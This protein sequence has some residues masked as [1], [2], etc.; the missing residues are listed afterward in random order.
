[1]HSDV[2]STASAAG[3]AGYFDRLYDT[4][5][6]YWWRHG[7]PY[8]LDPNDYPT[9]LLAQMTLRLLLDSRRI[10]ID[11]RRVRRALDLG[12]GEG[13]DSIRLA[14]LGY[15]VTA[16]DISSRA[17]KKIS[18]FAADAG[19][20]LNVEAADIGEYC[21]EGSFDVIMLNGVLHY[22]RDKAAIIDRMQAA[23]RPGGLHV[24]SAWSTYTPVPSCHNSIPVY[25]DPEDGVIA[26]AYRNWDLKLIYFE[27]NKPE[28]SHEGMPEHSHSHIKIIAEKPG[29]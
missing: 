28:R 11:G 24:V 21:P 20:D 16:V 17:T 6:R 23:T 19:A 9:A 5:E 8:S 22:T 10:G 27:R 12:A 2:H 18:E 26:R 3:V 4:E 14:R 25:C 13:A 1:V 29:S 7:D 15:E